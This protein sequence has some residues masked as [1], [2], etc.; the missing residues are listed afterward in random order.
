ML[1]SSEVYF[2]SL[3]GLRSLSARI[4]KGS[5]ATGKDDASK[6]TTLFRYQLS[7]ITLVKKESRFEVGFFDT[8][9]LHI[10]F[11]NGK[12]RSRRF[13]CCGPVIDIH[14]GLSELQAVR[15]ASV[16]KRDEAFAFILAHSTS[17]RLAAK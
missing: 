9:G 4:F 3:K 14:G 15:L 12:V 5:S 13:L 1:T 8:D 17:Q 10:A 7:T 16:S 6:A 11:N 2:N